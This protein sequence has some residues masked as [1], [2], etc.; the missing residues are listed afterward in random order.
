MT[1]V[2]T[3]EVDG[4]TAERIAAAK[5]GRTVSMCIPCR[6]EVAT[7]AR[8]SGRVANPD[9]NTLEIL[10]GLLENAFFKAIMPGFE[11]SA[12]KAPR[13]KKTKS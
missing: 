3:F 2:R 10:A 1:G 13:P 7:I 6:D 12:A 11:Q 8:L 9:A 5:A 4:C